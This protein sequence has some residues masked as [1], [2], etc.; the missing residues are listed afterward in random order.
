MYIGMNNVIQVLPF[1]TFLEIF[2][3]NIF[4]PWLVESTDE[5]PV[6]MEGWLYFFPA[7]GNHNFMNQS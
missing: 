4:D 5:E 2:F 3:L 1:L 7:P 6:D